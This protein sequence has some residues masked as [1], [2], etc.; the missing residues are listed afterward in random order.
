M[1]KL[2]ELSK[3]ELVS[4]LQTAHKKLKRAELVNK[5]LRNQV[6]IF[7]KVRQYLSEVWY[8]YDIYDTVSDVD[9]AK[10]C[11]KV[12]LKEELLYI[13]DGDK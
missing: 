11:G 3:D 13:I 10:L 12:A 2:T 4:L 7:Q 8:Y 5:R 9:S 1:P 6:R